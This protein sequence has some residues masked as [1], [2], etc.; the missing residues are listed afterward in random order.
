MIQELDPLEAEFQNWCRVPHPIAS[1]SEAMALK[2]PLETFAFRRTYIR[3]TESDPSEIGNSHFSD[4]AAR[5]QKSDA[6]GYH[7][8]KTN[9]MVLSNKP[10]EL[11]SLLQVIT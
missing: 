6:W 10:A 1:A 3:A 2:Q 7:E 8:I 5:A 9:H 4:A 11:A